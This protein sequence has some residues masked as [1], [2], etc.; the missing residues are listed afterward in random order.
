MTLISDGYQKEKKLTTMIMIIVGDW[1]RLW[2]MVNNADCDINDCWEPTV[3]SIVL[4][5][6]S[7]MVIVTTT[8]VFGFAQMVL[9]L[10]NSFR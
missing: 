5:G 7:L 10:R 9:V 6:W 3:V 4:T 1:P 8:H 2:L